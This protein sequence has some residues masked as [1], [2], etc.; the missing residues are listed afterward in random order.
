[1]VP[2]YCSYGS[3]GVPVTIFMSGCL[4]LYN[5]QYRPFCGPQAAILDFAGSDRVLLA[6]LGWYFTLFI[7]FKYKLKNLKVPKSNFKTNLVVFH[8]WLG[9]PSSV[10]IVVR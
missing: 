5:F 7:F 6:Q 8:F 10:M 3:T 1:M 2:Q 4:V 9:A